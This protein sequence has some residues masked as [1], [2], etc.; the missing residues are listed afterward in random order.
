[1]SSYNA[2]RTKKNPISLL[3]STFRFRFDITGT[4]SCDP[5]R[6]IQAQA[7]G[8]AFGQSIVK[9]L[10]VILT[11]IGLLSIN[12]SGAYAYKNHSM[13]LKLYAHNQIKDWEQ[14]NCYNR[15]IF[16]ESSW[17][18]WVRNGSHTGLGQM[19]SE[20]YGTLSPRK[21]IRVHLRYIEHRYQTPCKA[22]RHFNKIG[23]H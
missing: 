13:N 21:Q 16:K 18:Y 6:G 2:T 8:Y 22:E 4:L 9:F 5:T 3:T 23:W 1:M 20:W 7:R 17:R 12:T 11:S 19:R 14:F 10:L 15:L